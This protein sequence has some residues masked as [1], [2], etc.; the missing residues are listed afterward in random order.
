MEFSLK[1]SY[2][3]DDLVALVALLRSENGCPW[4]REQTHDSVRMNFLEEAYEAVE[5]IDLKDDRLLCEELGDVMLQVV[6]HAQI[7]EERGAFDV[8]GISDM[9]CKKLVERHPHVFAGREV[10][11]TGEVLVN[12]DEIKRRTK[13]ITSHTGAMRAVASSLPALMRAEK[14]QKKAAKAGFDWPDVS[15]ALDKLREETAELA[16]ADDDHAL[17]EMGDLLFAAVN[18]ARFR[19]LDPELALIRANEKFI[20]RFEMVERAASRLGKPI[21]SMTL[22]EMDELWAQAKVTEKHEK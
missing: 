4:D 10:S 19:K 20:R 6:F 2:E 8:S 21:D 16:Q 14:I 18:V 13:D 22:S 9:V 17:E 11:G 12:W 15:G 7:A 5:A 3:F 1:S